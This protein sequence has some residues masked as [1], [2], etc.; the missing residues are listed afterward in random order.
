M[1]EVADTAAAIRKL[2]GDRTMRE[3]ARGAGVSPSG[4]STYE[5]GK[6]RPRPPMIE[7]IARGLGCTP[8]ELE[9]QA[10]V[11]RRLRLEA[12]GADRAAGAADPDAG[13]GDATD[14]WRRDVNE[15]L[16]RVADE[17]TDLFVLLKRHLP[18]TA[19]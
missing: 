16:H 14:A 7:R 9:E 4:W 10:W 19:S 12:Q 15:Q 2:R 1:F 13:H 5:H 18:S 3:V 17:L 8:A 6:R 11:Q